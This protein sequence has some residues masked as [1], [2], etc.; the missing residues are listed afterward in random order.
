MKNSRLLV[1]SMNC[2]LIVEFRDDILTIFSTKNYFYYL[3]NFSYPFTRKHVVSHCFS[4]V[5]NGKPRT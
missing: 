1:R 3:S 2:E 5:S 4:S